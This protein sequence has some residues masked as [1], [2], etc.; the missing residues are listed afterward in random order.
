[1]NRALAAP[2]PAPL[3]V[4][5]VPADPDERS[6]SERIALASRT[7]F[8]RRAGFLAL[9]V[10]EERDAVS[11]GRLE[12]ALL[13]IGASGLVSEQPRLETIAA[14]GLNAE[15]K[16]AILALGELAA[17][18]VDPVWSSERLLERLLDDPDPQIAACALLA[19]LQGGEAEWRAQARRLAASE[20]ERLAPVASDLLEFVTN[21][22]EASPT[23]AA[24][25]LLDLRWS[26][27]RSFGLVDGRAWSEVLIEELRRDQ[28][29]LDHLVLLAAADLSPAP[30]KDHML[31]LLVD[32]SGTVRLRAVVR[33]MAGD[34]EKIMASGLWMPADDEEWYALVDEALERNL[35][36]F[37]P[38]LFQLALGQEST[39]SLAAGILGRSD[40]LFTEQLV[41]GL[42]R[43]EAVLRLRAIRGYVLLGDIS[44]ER[45]QELRRLDRDR[46]ARVRG[47]ALAARIRLGDPD[48]RGLGSILVTSEAPRDFQ[49]E[50]DRRALIQGLV[51]FYRFP[52]V[53]EFLQTH[54]SSFSPQEIGG[55]LACLF[56]RGRETDTR[57]L[58]EA[59]PYLDPNSLDALR[60]AQAV[61]R[62]PIKADLDFVAERF[63]LE[64]A[65]EVNGVLAQ[66]LLD[67]GHPKVLPLIEAAV[68]E[69]DLDRS[70][71]AA[72]VALDA[73]GIRTLLNWIDSPPARAD[74]E[75]LRRLGFAIG[76]W[77]GGE[78][79]EQLR[80]HLRIT[81]GEANH[82]ELQGA[83]LG[84]LVSRT[85]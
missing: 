67:Q 34:L 76:Q 75:D 36:R 83:L 5:S 60:V 50:V 71:L 84:F 30:V 58:H 35:E 28:E 41:G 33:S 12:A 69:K 19:L 82:P 68:W 3:P 81:T 22:L 23:A 61:A 26:A 51:Q 38:T 27:A 8:P 32:G 42:T 14:G 65:S 52:N 53:V 74:S 47:A 29:F 16:A 54:M 10:A 55:P 37:L 4:Q 85:H 62:A 17:S 2:A 46:D 31:G 1:M 7:S 25:L 39:E 78:G 45:V 48:A 18:G 13:A 49:L 43:P 66:I 44:T 57:L 63:P 64:N 70:L 21:P 20:G 6:W 79:L 11:S 80:S 40:P 77:R 56:L 15:R 72:A 9:R 24:E 73:G 59:L